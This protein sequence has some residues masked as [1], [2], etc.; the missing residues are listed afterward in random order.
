MMASHIAGYPVLQLREVAP[1]E[2][3]K[4]PG[5]PVAY[6]LKVFQKLDSKFELYYRLTSYGLL[7][8]IKYG[9]LL[10]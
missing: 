1:V 9:P 4:L 2:I 3:G 8:I 5:M 7:S 6:S 10:E